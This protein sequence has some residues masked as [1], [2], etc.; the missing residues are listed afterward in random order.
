MKQKNNYLIVGVIL[1]AIFL[2]IA[3]MVESKTISSSIIDLAQ[4]T[5]K[6]NSH[7][8]KEPMI[9]SVGGFIKPNFEVL[10]Y[11]KSKTNQHYQLDYLFGF[12][13]G[14]S[15]KNFNVMLGL[16]YFWEKNLIFIS[17]ATDYKISLDLLHFLLGGELGGG[18]KAAPACARCKFQFIFAPRF[19]LAFDIGHHS[20]LGLI[21]KIY[22]NFHEITTPYYALGLE[23]RIGF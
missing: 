11:Q 6:K 3:S 1:A 9:K 18:Y 19:G 14:Y 22:I 2:L 15:A 20:S 16:N 5:D 8:A 23:A 13:T 10:T 4:A 12:Y 17:T 7:E 21:S